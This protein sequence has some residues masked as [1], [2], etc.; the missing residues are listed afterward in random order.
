LNGTAL[1]PERHRAK[2]AKASD[3]HHPARWR[4][5]GCANHIALQTELRALTVNASDP[6]QCAS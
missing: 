6:D 5:L 1:F 3:G 2:V 4:Y